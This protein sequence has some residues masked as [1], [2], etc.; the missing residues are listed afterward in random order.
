MTYKI[1]NIKMIDSQHESMEME[2]ETKVS[3]ITF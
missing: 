2:I 1:L 3:P